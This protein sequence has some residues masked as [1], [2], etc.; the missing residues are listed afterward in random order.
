MNE[1][2]WRWHE[3]DARDLDGITLQNWVIPAGAGSRSV[4]RYLFVE[5]RLGPRRHWRHIFLRSEALSAAGALIL[6]DP[7]QVTFGCGRRRGLCR[8]LLLTCLDECSGRE[9]HDCR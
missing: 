9:D 5:L 1:L 8:R 3:H 2:S 7:G 6:P 4:S